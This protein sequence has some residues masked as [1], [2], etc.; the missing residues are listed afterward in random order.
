MEDENEVKE[1]VKE[2]GEAPEED[3]P[4]DKEEGP[5]NTLEM[6]KS[7]YK[8]DL[9]NPFQMTPVQ[10]QIF[11]SIFTKGQSAGG[12][13]RVHIM[14]YSQYGKNLAHDTPVLTN[15]GWKNHG[16]ISVGDYVFGPDGK[17]KRVIKLHP[18]ESIDREVTFSNGETIRCH[19]N[20]EWVVRHKNW[21]RRETGYKILE[22]K[23]MEQ[24]VLKDKSY[25]FSVP[26]V[27]PLDFGVS[28]ELPIDPYTLGAWLGDGK[29]DG[30]TI[31]GASDDLQHIIKKIPY[32]SG[33][34][35][36]HKTTGVEYYFY[37]KT[38]FANGLS[39]LKIKNNKHI[40]DIY[41]KASVEKRKA[42]I[43]GLIDTDGS[44]NKQE[45]KDGY[46]NGRV[47]IV[48]INKRLIDDVE[49]ILRTLGVRHVSVVK[50]PACVSSSGITGKS[51]VYYLGF[52]PTIDFP[53]AIPRKK[54]TVKN[55]KRSKTVTVTSIIKTAPKRGR[56]IT[57]EGGVYLVGRNLIPTHNSD[58]I[59]MAVLTR[60][61]VHP[62][63]WIIVA[64]SQPK[65]RIMVGF[66]IKHIFDNEF[67]MSRFSVKEGESIDVIRRERSKNKLT[68]DLGNNRISEIFIL[69][70][71][72]RLTSGEDAGNAM[73]GFGAPNV[74]YDEAALISDDA[75][76]KAL[77]MV[78][79]FVSAGADFVAK[80]GNPFKRNHFLKAYEDPDYHK[81]NADYLVGIREGRL[82]E[83]FIVEMRKKP[84][85][86]VLYENKFP[87]DEDIDAKGWTQL[88]TDDDVEKAIT[89]DANIAHIGEKR[90]GNDVARGGTNYTVWSLRSMN[91]L[92]VLGKSQQDNLTEI[93]GRTIF[94][95]TEKHVEYTNI[96]IDDVGVG[97]GAVD[98]LRYQQKKVNGVN[99]GLPAM[100][101]ARFVNIRA[102]AYWRFREWLKR[103][104]KLC[105]CHR[106]E[107]AQELPKIKYKPDLKG[108]L[109]IMSKDEMRSMGIDSPDCADSGMLTFI[110][111][112]HGDLEERKKKRREKQQKRKH[113]R[114]LKLTMA[115]Y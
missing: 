27:Y 6:V 110:R 78:G 2:F 98:P 102:E 14:T 24:Y 111:Q 93:A 114:G 72:S 100:E 76:A 71:E 95:A 38:E 8:D 15:E 51:D 25:C 22:T 115:G 53:T 105:N 86:R 107:W 57:V 84:Y 10:N 58:T 55:T 4:V 30:P 112:D 26:D 37:G 29:S 5:A 74:V 75:D 67:T 90:I 12:K 85:F 33:S 54:I 43:A 23:E 40:P 20:H 83:K 49:E 80:V 108:R 39:L 11:D 9:G 66:I 69:S 97:G 1:I 96:F 59:S 32:I 104:G 19:K 77:R 42:L 68:F 47:Y 35:T 60:A 63:K 50:I 31:C 73:M 46:Q 92:E 113:G 70:A 99:V 62:E 101:S 91:F 16:N 79:G 65:A 88:F 36:R 64:P 3:V 87:E 44:V 45:R 18:E 7:L 13:K 81:I 28:E 48:N 61:C 89:N 17:M 109:R 34:H 56:C 94:Y 106:D 41:K 103:G 52:S 21:L 82:T